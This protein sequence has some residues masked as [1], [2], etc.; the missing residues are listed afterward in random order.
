MLQAGW[1]LLWLLSLSLASPAYASLAISSDAVSSSSN[2][3]FPRHAHHDDTPPDPTVPLDSAMWVSLPCYKT[4]SEAWLIRVLTVCQMG[5]CAECSTM[6]DLPIGSALTSLHPDGHSDALLGRALSC[7]HGPRFNAR[8][9][10]KFFCTLIL[11]TWSSPRLN[12]RS[13]ASSNSQNG[14]CPGNLQP[15]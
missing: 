1:S 10:H 13:V 11:G 5:A 2:L 6:F 14:T 15:L 8:Q 3:F 12:N 4:E 7:R 9:Y